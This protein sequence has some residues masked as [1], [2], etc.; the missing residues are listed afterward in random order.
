MKDYYQV[1]FED[2]ILQKEIESMPGRTAFIDESGGFGFDFECDGTPNYYILCAIIVDNNN[3]KK[4]HEDFDIIKKDN[5][6]TKGELKSS[7][8]TE[9]RR[10]HILFQLLP[11]DFNIVLLIADKKKFI[12]GSVLTEYKRSFIKFLNQHLY[13]MLYKAYPKLT[14]LQD[15]TGTDEFQ[16]SFQN[17]VE[18]NRIDENLLNE[19][20]FNFINSRDETL[21]QLADYVAGSMYHY[22]TGNIEYNYFA[23]FKSKITVC[24]FFPNDRESYW[25][26]VKPEDYNYDKSIFDIALKSVNDFIIRKRNSKERDHILQVK[27][28]EYL[29]NSVV[30]INPTKFVFAD[31][32]IDYLFRSTGIKVSRNLL[33]TNVIAHLRDEGVILSSS[34][35]GYKIPISVEDV[36]V[37]MNQ[38]V[39]T[40]GP[41]IERMNKCRSLIKANTG[42]ELDLFDQKA[43][44]KY[45]RYF[46]EY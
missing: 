30:F 37:Y 21:I 6:F 14:I 10:K 2:V 3:I 25:G 16:N 31:E 17:Y 34:V 39:S 23:A 32:L 15:E 5:G 45:K 24:D 43:F 46:G 8:L 27:T 28:L 7:K 26:R 20:D 19:Y 29:K 9:N 38:T 40:V 41:M 13:D 36:M 12:E 42:N 1:S 44:I 11:L 18:E 35:R 22:F 33:Y 4:L